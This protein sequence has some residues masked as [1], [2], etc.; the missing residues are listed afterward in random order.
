MN[1]LIKYTEAEADFVI[2]ELHRKQSVDATS[3][4]DVARY[5]ANRDT[6]GDP[7]VI[8]EMAV[9]MARGQMEL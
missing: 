4:A 1:G 7:M 9:Y 3:A 8:A 6:S 2:N 5:A